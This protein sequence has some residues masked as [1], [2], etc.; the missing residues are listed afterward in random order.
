MG[1]YTTYYMKIYLADLLEQIGNPA[2]IDLEDFERSQC[3]DL[4]YRFK[5]KYRILKK[6]GRYVIVPPEPDKRTHCQTLLEKFNIPP[7]SISLLPQSRKNNKEN[8][9]RAYN[10][11]ISRLPESD[12]VHLREIKYYSEV[13]TPWLNLNAVTKSNLSQAW[14][15][16]ILKLS[17]I[18][19]A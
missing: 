9:F 2:N 3:I 15:D 4:W 7:G 16:F 10:F 11:I 19:I 1:K 18:F 8:F 5:S 12:R 17:E 13:A 14:K 6:K